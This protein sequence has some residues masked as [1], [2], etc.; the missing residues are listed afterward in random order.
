[1][2]V[3]VVGACPGDERRL[4]LPPELR[5]QYADADD[6]PMPDLREPPS[7]YL[8]PRMIPM[9]YWASSMRTRG[10]SRSSIA[11]L[12]NY[13]KSVRA[14]EADHETLL[15]FT[16]ARGFPLGEHGRIGSVGDVP[17]SELVQVLLM[18]RLP[19][20]AMDRDAWCSLPISMRRCDW[21]CVEQPAVNTWPKYAKPRACVRRTVA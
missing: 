7:L 18:L 4:E 17:Y 19:G 13:S 21:L 1:M 20:G 10:R 9:S 6:P 12:E 2:A 11:V 8:A 15:V 14:R 5:T 16:S 3:A